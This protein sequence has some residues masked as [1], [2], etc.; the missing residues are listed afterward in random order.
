LICKG[1]KCRSPGPSPSPAGKLGGKCGT[2]IKCDD[3]L[4][5]NDSI[6][7]SSPGPSTDQGLSTPAVVGI[8]VGGALLL[9][10]IIF[11]IAHLANKKRKVVSNK[12]GKTKAI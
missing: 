10:G 5:C 6:C 2:T 7:E 1:N 3:G 11:G 12:C 8:S 4:Y 9:I